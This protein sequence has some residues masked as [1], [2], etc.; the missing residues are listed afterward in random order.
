MIDIIVLILYLFANTL[1]NRI[2]VVVITAEA[3]STTAPA[4]AKI[5]DAE[6]LN[7]NA[8]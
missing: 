1:G 3:P 8:Q 7:A 6:I 5:C 4:S 2:T